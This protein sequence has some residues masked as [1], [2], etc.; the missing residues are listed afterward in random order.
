MIVK[1]VLV[2]CGTAIATATVVANKIK[3][4]CKANGIK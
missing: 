1:K 3:E 4:L 2:A